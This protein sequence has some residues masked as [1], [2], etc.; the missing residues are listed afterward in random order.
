[1]A[2]IDRTPVGIGIVDPRWTEANISTVH[3]SFTEE[4][5]RP[6]GAKAQNNLQDGLP[7][8]TG[9]Q[10]ESVD[11]KVTKSGNP[12]IAERGAAVAWKP[13][14]SPDERWRGWSG[15]Q[16]PSS[17]R[18][19]LRTG[20]AIRDIDA[21]TVPSTQAVVV[22]AHDATNVYARAT[23]GSN[24]AFGGSAA[25]V[26]TSVRASSVCTLPDDTILVFTAGLT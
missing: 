6:G 9:A 20:S 24:F 23:N 2:R 3:S 8:I 22:I 13:S 10:A 25:V 5:P 1:M 16:F 4:G 18:P 12:S 15:P 11:I 21:A 7:V 17:Y 19:I 14:L 26:A